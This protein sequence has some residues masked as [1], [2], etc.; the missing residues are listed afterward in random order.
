MSTPATR[1]GFLKNT[2]AAAL[3]LPVVSAQEA[4]LDPTLV[5]LDSGIEPLVRLIE[6]T[7]RG[8]LLEEVGARVKKG[9]GYRDVVTAL[10]LAGVRNIRPHGG[11]NF[12]A[13]L[14]IHAAHQASLDAPD[15]DR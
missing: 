10:F 3:G 14:V 9:L 8:K 5:R 6:L 15:S 11:D 4:K 1:R 2:A 7:P 12:H 13:V